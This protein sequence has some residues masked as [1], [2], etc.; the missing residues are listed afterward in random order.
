MNWIALV[1]SIA[2]LIAEAVSA[3]REWKL[4]SLGEAHGRAKSESAHAR[5]ATERREEMRKI[6][7]APPGR[8]DI[9]KRLGEGSA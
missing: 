5:E 2:K 7:D 8:A 6:A 1:S 4:I 9:E 3:L